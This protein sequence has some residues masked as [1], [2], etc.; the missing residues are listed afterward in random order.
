[1]QIKLV[2]LDIPGAPDLRRGH[3]RLNFRF[4]CLASEVPAQLSDDCLRDFALRREHVRQFQR[5]E[6]L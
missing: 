5:T 2:R 1:V 4:C 6:A 3:L